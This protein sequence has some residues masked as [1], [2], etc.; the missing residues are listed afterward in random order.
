MEW[1]LLGTQI[2]LILLAGRGV[3]Y[4]GE[5]MHETNSHHAEMDRVLS[6]GE[7]QTGALVREL[8]KI[9]DRISRSSRA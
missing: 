4:L 1:V 2:V 9:E 3:Y 5:I 8:R 6:M 7:R